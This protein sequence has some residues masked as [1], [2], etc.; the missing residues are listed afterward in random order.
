MGNQNIGPK[1]FSSEKIKAAKKLGPKSLVKCCFDKYHHDSLHMLQMIPGHFWQFSKSPQ[2]S[3][4][5]PKIPN[6]TKK[7]PKTPITPNT[8]RKYTKTPKTSKNTPKYSKI[9][10]N[11]QKH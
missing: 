5:H 8:I 11:T 3:H 9:P 1:I 6:N 4:K 7:H 10:K 2:Y